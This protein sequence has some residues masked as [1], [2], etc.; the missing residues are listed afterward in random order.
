MLGNSTDTEA[1]TL[2]QNN[3]GINHPFLPHALLLSNL[4]PAE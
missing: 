2:L 1:A 4:A 3:G